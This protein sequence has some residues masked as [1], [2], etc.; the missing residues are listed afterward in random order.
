MDRIHQAPPKDS[1]PG[2]LTQALATISQRA[3]DYDTPQGERSAAHAAV[4]FNAIRRGPHNSSVRMTELDAWYFM[5]A[6]KLARAQQG[7]PKADTYLDLSAYCALAGET[8]LRPSRGEGG[9]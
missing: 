5:I 1:A 4:I 8:A 9:E 2:L 7:A 3:T 6:L